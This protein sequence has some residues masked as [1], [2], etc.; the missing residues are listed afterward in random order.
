MVSQL[1]LELKTSI[2]YDIT[3]TSPGKALDEFN[4][5]NI[6]ELNDDVRKYEEDFKISDND[7]NK[8][9]VM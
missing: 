4:I 5:E 7:D 9:V 8:M 1:K 3:D 2:E 6:L